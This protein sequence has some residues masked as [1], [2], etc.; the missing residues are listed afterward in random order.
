MSRFKGSFIARLAVVVTVAISSALVLGGCGDDGGGGED[1]DGGGTTPTTPNFG[2]LSYGGQTYK[3]IKIGNQTW[4]AENLNYETTDSWCYENNPSNCSTYGRLYTWDAAMT[5]C[6]AGWHLPTNAEW[7]ALVDAAGG[8]STAGAK[9]KT[10]DWG[11]TNNYGFSALPGGYRL[12]VGSFYGLGSYGGWRAATEND[13][14]S[15]YL[16][17]MRTN[18]GHVVSGGDGKDGG[19]SVR[20][21][22]N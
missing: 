19:Y 12:Y 2:S 1:G 11:G 20:C 16:W 21:L 22:Q 3:T 5:A 7:Q 14:G 6:P 17:T 8:A 10:S 4:M 18:D 9:L 13:I 15:A